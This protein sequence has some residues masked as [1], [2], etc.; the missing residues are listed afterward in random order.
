MKLCTGIVCVKQCNIRLDITLVS[1]YLL[2][3]LAM[4]QLKR[5]VAGFPPRRPGFYPRSSHVGFVVEKVAL[6]QVFSEYFGFP[7]QSS[8]HRLLHNH[9]HLSSGAGTIGQQW[10]SYQVDSVSPHPEKLKKTC[11]LFSEKKWMKEKVRNKDRVKDRK[12]QFFLSFLPIC[13]L[14]FYPCIPCFPLCLF[15]CLFVS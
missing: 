2:Y 14:S 5:L 11:F 9:H 13:L 1:D 4:S 15:L 10:P 3:L 6:E 7:C 12:K 8:F